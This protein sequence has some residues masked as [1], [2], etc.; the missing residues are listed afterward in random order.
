MGPSPL[1]GQK[2]GTETDVDCG[3]GGCMT[4]SNGKVCGGLANG[5][6]DCTSGFCSATA[7]LCVATACLDQSQDNAETDVDCGGGTCSTCGGGKKCLIGAD[8]ATTF[9]SATDKLCVATACLDQ[10]KNN[11]ETAIDCGGP[12]CPKCGAGEACL[13]AADCMSGFCSTTDKLC[14]ANQCQDQ[15]KNGMETD[16]D[17]GGPT[18]PKC[19][20]TF[21]CLVPT[22]CV[23]F[24]NN[25]TL[26]CQAATCPDGLKNGTEADVDCGAPTS[27]CP[28]ATCGAMK[29][30]TVN[31]ECTSAMCIGAAMCM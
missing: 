13:V 8:C 18:C 31:E 21:A 19:A 6:R 2:N 14:V 22:D 20:D 28:T 10:T 30:C 27:T 25:V 15:V 12:T 4:C 17:C 11:A 7:K 24:C 1:D 3:G 16:I 9:C 5:V 23:S 29:M 26:V